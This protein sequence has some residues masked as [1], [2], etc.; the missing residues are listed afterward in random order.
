MVVPPHSLGCLGSL[1]LPSR[2]GAVGPESVA[3]RRAQLKPSHPFEQPADWP[4]LIADPVT[5]RSGDSHAQLGRSDGPAFRD[6]C[7]H[8]GEMPPPKQHSLTPFVL[9]CLLLVCV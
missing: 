4:P 8:L 1:L 2:P 9:R 3:L 7:C 5:P 6:S